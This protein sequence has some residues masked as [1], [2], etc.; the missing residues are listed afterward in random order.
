MMILDVSIIG[1][2]YKGV[3]LP[4]FTVIHVKSILS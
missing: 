3:I 4:D 1:K 2:K